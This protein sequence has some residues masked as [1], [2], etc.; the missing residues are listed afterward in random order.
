ML[1][2]RV[3]AGDAG[4]L[5]RGEETKQATRD[6]LEAVGYTT[7]I[8]PGQIAAATQFL[9]DVGYGE[10]DPRTFGEWYEGLTTGRL[11]E[12]SP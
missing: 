10:Q 2:V 4:K 3:E 7:G 5:A 6:T 8:V 1:C 11:Q 9:V 12:A